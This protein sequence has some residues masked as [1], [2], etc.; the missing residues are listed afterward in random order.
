[1]DKTQEF[2][3]LYKGYEEWLDEV[4]P[5]LPLPFPEGDECNQD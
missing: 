3:D 1:M 5:T 4:E 2:D